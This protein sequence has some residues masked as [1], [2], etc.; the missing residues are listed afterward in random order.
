MLDR[1]AVKK[2]DELTF[3]DPIR[4]EPEPVEEGAER[5]IDA[6]Y[7]ALSEVDTEAH[8][9]SK[10][11]FTAVFEPVDDGQELAAYEEIETTQEGLEH[12][13]GEAFIENESR[14]IDAEGDQ[15][16]D[17]AYSEDKNQLKSVSES[18]NLP[19]TL[20][21]NE[22]TDIKGLTTILTYLFKREMKALK[23]LLQTELKA[24]K[25]KL[26]DKDKK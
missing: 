15:S 8:D 12:E 21:E 11:D 17:S 22:K 6:Q 16:A 25:D 24:L 18:D 1:Q 23:D 5:Q 9:L 3:P 20:K 13:L 4:A 7:E 14:P 19:E 2:G 26:R 10:Q